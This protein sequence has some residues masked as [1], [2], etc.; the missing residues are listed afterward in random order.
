MIMF[1]PPADSRGL[2]TSSTILG[3]LDSVALSLYNMEPRGWAG[4]GAVTT[5][6]LVFTVVL[7][8]V[9][10]PRAPHLRA[11]WREVLLALASSASLSSVVK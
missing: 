8:A 1:V 7:A 2:A 9:T 4:G 5:G 10:V 6:A 3:P 11:G